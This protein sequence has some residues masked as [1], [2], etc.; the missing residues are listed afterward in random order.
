M[1]P[2]VRSSWSAAAA[3]DDGRCGRNCRTRSI[4]SLDYHSA[5]D[6]RG[7]IEC[8]TVPTFTRPTLTRK[9]SIRVARQGRWGEKEEEHSRSDTP[10]G[11]AAPRPPAAPIT[12]SKALLQKQHP[13]FRV[14]GTRESSRTQRPQPPRREMAI[15]K[16][17][18]SAA[19]RPGS[20]IVALCR[21]PS[22]LA[23]RMLLLRGTPKRIGGRAA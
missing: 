5:F 13:C 16:D 2:R 20:K 9:P 14:C 1:K 4:R 11:D 19:G 17:R 7:P 8:C 3:V 15:R 23:W 21:P 22:L 6:R 12:S 18:T 10:R